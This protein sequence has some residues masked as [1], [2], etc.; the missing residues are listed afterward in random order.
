MPVWITY[1]IFSYEQFK[2]Q[3][4]KICLS[5]FALSLLFTFLLLHALSSIFWNFPLLSFTLLPF[6]STTCFLV[7]L[8]QFISFSNSMFISCT[9]F[10][11][12][13]C[14]CF[15]REQT[16]LMLFTRVVL[17]GV[18]CLSCLLKSWMLRKELEFGHRVRI[19]CFSLNG[20]ISGVAHSISFLIDHFTH[21][22]E[23]W[24]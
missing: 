14:V 11:F 10:L 1:Y 4:L 2:L 20:A 15:C 7:F 9:C 17:T 6:S 13:H 21:C 23:N 3:R 5:S 8:L 19:E 24:F 22:T 12:R 16:F 18:K